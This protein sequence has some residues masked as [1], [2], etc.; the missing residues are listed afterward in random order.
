M[1]TRY[2]NTMTIKINGVAAHGISSG[3]AMDAMEKVSADVLP[4]GYAYEWTGVSLQEKEA[5]GQTATILALAF[6]FTYF[7]LVALYESWMLP[8]PI[9]LSVPVGLCGALMFLYF[10]GLTN[11]IYAQIGLVILIGQCSKNAILIVEFAKVRVEEGLDPEAA[12]IEA[13]Y[14]RFRAVMMTAVSFL[15]GLIPLVI[16]TGAG[17]VARR[18][19]GTA[20]FGGMTVATFIGILVVPMLFVVFVRRRQKFHTRRNRRIEKRERKFR[21]SLQQQ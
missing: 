1:L 7:F 20:V 21:E 10:G 14:L 8:L 15:L 18:S 6:L 3:Q 16:A 13:S 19:V 11:N 17:A 4:K 2:N 12:A 5:A 9:L